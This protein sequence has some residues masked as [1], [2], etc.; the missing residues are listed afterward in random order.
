MKTLLPLPLKEQKRSQS[1][2][3]GT[4]FRAGGDGAVFGSWYDGL[5]PTH[6]LSIQLNAKV[7][8]HHSQFDSVGYVVPNADGS[9]LLTG[10]GL[11]TPDLQP[12][13][14]DKFDNVHCVPA[15]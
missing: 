13:D 1:A 14:R 2:Y 3:F 15:Y 11:F 6:L 9:L 8:Q 10:K 12:V 5:T 7:A 4:E